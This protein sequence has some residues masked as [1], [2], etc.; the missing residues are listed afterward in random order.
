[1]HRRRTALL[2]QAPDQYRSAHPLQDRPIY[3]RADPT[4]TM[5]TPLPIDLDTIAIAS[6]ASGVA[7]SDLAAA[8][9]NVQATIAAS[10]E[11]TA[12]V[13]ATSQQD[14]AVMAATAATTSGAATA[15]TDLA[16]AL[17][18]LQARVAAAEAEAQQARAATTAL[19]LLLVTPRVTVLLIS[20]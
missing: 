7:L 11:R 9:A 5:A 14:Q 13:E 16:T 15:P 12:A 1:M 10:C 6:T 8:L 20:P 18:A 3:S 17:A 19:E 4:S 2:L